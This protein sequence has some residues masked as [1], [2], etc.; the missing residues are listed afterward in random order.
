LLQN[1][2]KSLVLAN[3]IFILLL[4][5]AGAF[6]G[7]SFYWGF[8]LLSFFDLPAAL[9]FFAAGCIVFIPK[10]RESVLLSINK[11]TASIKD[12]YVPALL[13]V[14]FTTFFLI[15][16]VKL[17]FLGD[18]PM[19][20]R[21]LPQMESVSDMIAT[22]EPGIYAVNLFVQSLLM[23]IMKINYSP[24]YV[25]LVL[26]YISGLTFTII[27]YYFV[28]LT[29]KESFERFTLFL[30]LF[31]TSALLFFTGYV[32]TYQLIYLIEL[33]YIT[34]SLFFIQKKFNNLFIVSA[35][36]GIWLS[37]HYLAAVFIPSYL[38]MLYLQLRR[39]KLK[40]VFSI[41]IFAVSFYGM[42]LLTGLDIVEMVKR[43]LSPNEPHWLP[44]TGNGTGTI[45]ALSFTH[46]WDVLNSQILVLPFGIIALT[47]FIVIFY[48]K[49]DYKDYSIIF[50]SAMAVFSAGFILFFNSHM[51]LSLDWDI[52]AL[53]SFPFIFLLIVLISKT[54]N[55]L[56]IKHALLIMGYL[57][58]WQTMMWIVLNTTNT[59]SIARNT[60]L[61]NETLWEKTKL[62][63]YY[64]SMGV[65]YRN[66]NDLKLSEEKFKKSVQY[67][68]G[69]ERLILSL[70]YVY[71]RE[72]KLND[73][74]QFLESSL[75][76]GI[77][78]KKILS[79]LGVIEMMM[80]NYDNA[81][82]YLEQAL[83][84]DPN[85]YETA[86]NLAGC[87][88]QKKEYNKS[89]EYSN[90]VIQLVPET[91]LAYI[92][93]GDSYLGLG[94]TLKAKFNYE[95]AG[96]KDREGRY[97]NLIESGINKTIKK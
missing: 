44:L 1:K 35:A 41:L 55:L 25:Y 22:N 48:K 4:F 10:F 60:H 45:P 9:F 5:T 65:F 88:N 83:Q 54:E 47:L 12:D 33:I 21:M 71:Q 87:Y 36:I 14:F 70:S 26:S 92:S 94:D 56:N 16:R 73:A 58:V 31:F 78:T 67:S 6:L 34:A 82:L 27:L 49:I 68:P 18:G 62:S 23:S 61:E 40:A 64:E 53:M 74:K 51:G 75:K 95:T 85:D 63:V 59:Y 66:I 79:R 90:K 17:H 84:L 80:Q 43:F 32:E 20:L 76:D 2:F 11:F 39:D 3:G 97:K 8:N 37:L 24:D 13:I 91:P 50:L 30:I 72:D 19:I 96:Q 28:K 86:G 69:N 52:I 57:S 77:K 38:F 15:F 89:I 7:S 81:V 29:F 46:L 42:F 93:L